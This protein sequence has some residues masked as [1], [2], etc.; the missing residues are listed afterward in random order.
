MGCCTSAWAAPLT[1]L[2]TALPS[3][4]DR[5]QCA[6]QPALAPVTSL[7][8]PAL[9]LVPTLVLCADPGVPDLVA[10]QALLSLVPD[11]VP[12]ADGEGVVPLADPSV[13]VCVDRPQL[14]EVGLD[15]CLWY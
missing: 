11:L 10:T 14:P 5:P 1:T 2:L 15:N 3:G 13:P 9:M 8:T 12:E 4:L 6:S 7:P